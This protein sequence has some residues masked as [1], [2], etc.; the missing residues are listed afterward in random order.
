MA[1]HFDDIGLSGYSPAD[2]D[3]L[4]HDHVGSAAIFE[5]GDGAYARIDM[6][7]GLCCWLCFR[8]EEEG[9][10]LT[11]EDFH[12]HSGVRIPVHFYEVL[13]QDDDG[14][15]GMIRV[16]LYEDEIGTEIPLNLSL[17]VLLPASDFEEGQR[18]FAQIA[19]YAEAA[20]CWASVH[21]YECS[22]P[23]KQHLA[24]EHLIPAGT[25]SPTND[26]DFQQSPRALLGGIVTACERCRNEI[27]GQD[28][29]HVTLHALGADYDILVAADEMEE[30]PVVGGVLHGAFW[31]TAMLYASEDS[32]DLSL[33]APGE[34]DGN[35]DN[36]A[37]SAKDSEHYYPD[38]HQ[39][40]TTKQYLSFTT[41]EFV[42]N[43]RVTDRDDTA[44]FRIV[45]EQGKGV[46]LSDSERHSLKAILD[47]I[48]PA[49]HVANID[50]DGL[51]IGFSNDPEGE[52]SW[53]RD[54]AHPERYHIS[55]CADTL[56]DWSQTIYQL[57][58]AFTHCVLDA[59]YVSG[60]VP[61][62][63]E[64]IC[65]MIQVWLV[66]FFALN[67]EHCDLHEKDQG[68]QSHLQSYLQE[69]LTDQEWTDQPG[70]CASMKELLAMN[71]NSADHMDERV[72]TV[73][74]LYYL[75][76]HDSLE[77]LLRYGSYALED[78]RLIN[79]T[80]WMKDYPESLAVRYLASIQDNA[81]KDDPEYKKL[82]KEM[83][84]RQADFWD[85]F[86]DDGWTEEKVMSKGAYV[87][88]SLDEQRA[89]FGPCAHE[90]ADSFSEM[91]ALAMSPEQAGKLGRGTQICIDPLLPNGDTLYYQ[92]NKISHLAKLEG[93]WERI[94]TIPRER[95]KE[96]M[97]IL[98]PDGLD[99]RYWKIIS[100]IE[101]GSIQIIGYGN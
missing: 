26:P 98:Y 71:E 29:W 44:A 53:K 18:V 72:G 3:Q 90:T 61:W 73:I 83:E 27:S 25:F 68:Y 94:V 45:F 66:S 99:D 87:P 70:H 15:N 88:Y 101:G 2:L 6:G 30:A 23:D 7:A 67:W 63:E 85:R 33:A 39:E 14:M 31:L 51:Q 28:Y 97:S 69:Y 34:N 58:Y 32:E 96:V 5:V 19:G 57:G 41:G 92:L 93:D 79:T 54:A 77:G 4:F 10:V 47:L 86:Y 48:V 24:A 62:M 91:L 37:G 36:A 1:T 42:D 21:A 82:L 78:T 95:I 12:F 55:L 80:E 84:E 8:Q 75:T 20:K 52:L 74:H 56:D 81:V 60:K 17:P 46:E 59:R 89:I 50:L 65:E 100:A 13:E 9:T 11:N 22:F 43:I 64:T 35:D 38:I 40:K 76:R 49:L 16:G